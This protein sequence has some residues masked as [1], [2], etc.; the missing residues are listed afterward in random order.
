MLEHTERKGQIEKAGVP[1]EGKERVKLGEEFLLFPK[2][3]TEVS[4]GFSRPSFF[5]RVDLAE[6]EFVAPIS[7]EVALTTI[8]K[9]QRELYRQ[10]PG[11]HAPFVTPVNPSSGYVIDEED[12]DSGRRLGKLIRSSELPV[13]VDEAVMQ[14]G[15]TLNVLEL[16]KMGKADK[17]H[18]IEKV[19]GASNE[20]MDL[21][22]RLRVYLSFPSGDYE[23]SLSRGIS[24]Y[25]DYEFL[26]TSLLGRSIPYLEDLNTHQNGLVMPR[27]AVPDPRSLRDNNVTGRFILTGAQDSL[28]PGQLK[29]GQGS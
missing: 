20:A 8:Q 15:V 14:L 11:V 3:K 1:Q 12:F 29:S 23:L 10:V 18:P 27:I 9:R 6:D 5:R 22:G 16:D 7:F 4:E 25:G 17:W 24:S 13:D 26:D 2:G 21:L 28:M 19:Y